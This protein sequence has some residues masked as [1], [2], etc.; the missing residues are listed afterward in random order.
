MR[1]KFDEQLKSLNEEMIRMSSMIE[2]AIKEA[3]EALLK[4]DVTKA[5]QIMEN[6]DY[7]DQEQKRIE[8][9]CFQLLI[10]QQPVAKDL[11]NIT[12]A[13][14]MVTDMERIGDHAAD[15]SELTVVLSDVPYQVKIDNIKDMAKESI[16]MLKQAVTAYV[17]SDMK[18]AREVIEHDDVVDEL[19][20]KVKSDLIDVMQNNTAYEEHAADLLMVN[21]YLERIGDHATN[22]AEWVIFSLDDKGI[23]KS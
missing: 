3:I 10:Q 19:F 21:K 20:C 13:M 6:D 2:N 22:I 1:S 9:I 18:M 11:R 23:K 7:I 4:Q 14:K 15:I 5:R 16:D 12:A 8:N 17:D